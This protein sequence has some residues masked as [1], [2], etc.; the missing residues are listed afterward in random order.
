MIKLFGNKETEKIYLG[1]VSKKYPPDIQQIARRKLKML[2]ASQNLK[3]LRVPPAN[4]LEKL[5]GNLSSYHSIRV[6]Q[7]WR[8]IFIWYENDAL[9]VQLV[10]YH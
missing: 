7:Q 9:D 6:N 10:D 2:H 4:R 8:I 1:V 5:K 3:D